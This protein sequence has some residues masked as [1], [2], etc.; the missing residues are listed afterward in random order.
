VTRHTTYQVEPRAVEILTNSRVRFGDDF[1]KELFFDLLEEGLLVTGKGGPGVQM[2]EHVRSRGREAEQ[3]ESRYRR[4]PLDITSELLNE[5]GSF[6]SFGTFKHRYG[7]DPR[8][9][10]DDLR[11]SHRE[12]LREYRSQLQQQLQE[13]ITTHRVTSIQR[14]ANRVIVELTDES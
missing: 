11:R 4:I 8:L 13:I 10:D 3:N 5:D 1:G 9:S 14:E 2:A 6:I 12:L 7:D